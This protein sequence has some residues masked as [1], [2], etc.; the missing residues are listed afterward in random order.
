MQF[1]MN[2]VCLCWMSVAELEGRNFRFEAQERDQVAAAATE[3]GLRIVE[4]SEVAYGRP[5]RYRNFRF[6]VDATCLVRRR[7]GS[8]ESRCRLQRSLMMAAILSVGHSPELLRSRSLLLHS[9]G[10]HVTEETDCRRALELVFHGNFNLLLLCHSLE[11][12][13]INFLVEEV[14]RKP[15]P[16][17]VLCIR[18]HDFASIPQGYNTAASAPDILLNRVEG[19]L[20]LGRK[21]GE[22]NS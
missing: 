22:C 18:Q 8:A 4:S 7:A 12:S 13:E 9:R 14:C 17:P 1:D 15:N 3:S 19:I 21:S 20:A 11:K 2:L 16:L 10:F 5:L 6:D